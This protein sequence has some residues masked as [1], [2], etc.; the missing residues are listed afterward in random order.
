MA[1]AGY[2][3]ITKFLTSN[4]EPPANPQTSTETTENKAIDSSTSTTT[5]GTTRKLRSIHQNIL[6]I[7]IRN[8]RSVTKANHHVELLQD[9]IDRKDPPKGQGLYLC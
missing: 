1:S 2:N 7:I 5:L 9:A 4:T 8:Q 6:K 3:T